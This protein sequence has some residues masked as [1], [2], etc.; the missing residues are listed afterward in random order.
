MFQL[1]SLHALWLQEGIELRRQVGARPLEGLGKSKATSL[2]AGSRN[3]E[4]NEIMER[5]APLGEQVNLNGAVSVVPEAAWAK[6]P[7]DVGSG[8]C[9]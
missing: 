3:S 9:S 1:N 6:H 5:L 7:S 8:G 2:E 4:L